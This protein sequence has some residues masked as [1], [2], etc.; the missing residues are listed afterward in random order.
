M[1]WTAAQESCWLKFLTMLRLLNDLATA[2]LAVHSLEFWQP[3]SPTCQGEALSV[4]NPI[5]NFQ[6]MSHRSC[7]LCFAECLHKFY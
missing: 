4:L 7:T 6:R 5:P 1:Q 3:H 2:S